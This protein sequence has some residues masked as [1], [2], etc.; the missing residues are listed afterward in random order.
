MPKS[1][2]LIL[3]RQSREIAQPDANANMKFLEIM[4]EK[5]AGN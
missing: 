3:N 5:R 2:F 4:A 1:Q